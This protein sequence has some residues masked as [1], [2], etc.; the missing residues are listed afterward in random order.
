MINVLSNFSN[1]VFCKGGGFK[2]GAGGEFGGLGGVDVDDVALD[3]SGDGSAEPDSGAAD[4]CARGVLGG[5]AGV[6]VG[7]DGAFESFRGGGK[8]ARGGIGGGGL[9]AAASLA[10][11]TAVVASAA[12]AGVL[13]LVTARAKALSAKLSKL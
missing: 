3:F 2:C 12:W 10:R 4:D 11:A 9:G 6:V 13:G 5:F 1:D 8:G 7:G